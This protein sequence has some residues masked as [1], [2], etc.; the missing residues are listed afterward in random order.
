MQCFKMRPRRASLP[1]LGPEW[2][3]FAR[4]L[5]GSPLAKFCPFPLNVFHRGPRHYLDSRPPLEASAF[6]DTAYMDMKG[7]ELKSRVTESG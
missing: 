3:V 5:L 7:I 6:F 4:M 1:G 2:P